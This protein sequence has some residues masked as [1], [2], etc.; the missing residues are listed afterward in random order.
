MVNTYVNGSCYSFIHSFIHSFILEREE[1]TAGRGGERER[2]PS[3]LHS[4]SAEPNVGLDL[5]NHETIILSQNQ[6]SDTCQTEPLRCPRV[7][8]PEMLVLVGKVQ[9]S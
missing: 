7:T 6:E 9:I 8:K 4:V 1:S 3:R 2:L 5:T